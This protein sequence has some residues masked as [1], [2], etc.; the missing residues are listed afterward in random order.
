MNGVTCSYLRCLIPVL[1]T[2]AH[3]LQSF[4]WVSCFP[5]FL[6]LFLQQFVT[7]CVSMVVRVL[8]QMF[9][10]VLMDSLVPSVRMVIFF[11][12]PPPPCL[13]AVMWKSVRKHCYLKTQNSQSSQVPEKWCKTEITLFFR[14]YG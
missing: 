8:S 2:E 11:F 13:A 12:F 9:A 1:A 14:F 3:I 5:L 4:I 7:L 6:T 10:S